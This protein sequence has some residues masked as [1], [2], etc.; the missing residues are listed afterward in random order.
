MSTPGSTIPTD[1]TTP[2]SRELCRDP[3]SVSRVPALRRWP[4]TA[5]LR[6]RSLS[7]RFS[8]RTAVV[9]VLMVLVLMALSVLGLMT[10]DYDLGPGQIMQALLGA[11]QDPL[12]GY[13]VNDLRAPRVVA[14][15]VVGAA[16]GVAGA[17]IQ[18]LTGNPLGSPDILGFTTGAATGALLQIIVLSGDGSQVALGALLGGLGT[19]VLVHLVTRGAGLTGTRLILVGLGV[20]AL[21]S[22]LNT[23]LV[24]R[25][26]L[27][28]A[29]TAAQWLAGSLNAMQW[30]RVLVTGALVLVLLLLAMAV[31]GAW[32]LLG[33]G[34][35]LAQSLG[36]PVTAVRTWSLLVA[37]ALVSLAT[38][39]TG[40]IAFVALAAPQIGRRLA[41]TAMPGILL[42]A[43]T[44]AALVL[45]SDIIAQRLLAPTQL[46]VGV[47][48]GALGGLYLIA[49]LVLDWKRFRP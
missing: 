2:N 30:H 5:T 43:L 29:Q 46:A 34:D 4:R 7:V 10:G 22:A 45:A 25:A 42:S 13:F 3:G 38:A 32:H 48:T 36:V 33:L 47:V 40:P 24:V 39:A 27:T 31:S 1:P 8:P 17:L 11:P 37:V 26:S 41:G 20:G 14:A 15:V 35:D 9:A 44:G 23:L 28:A 16:L 12:A 6:V 18:G 49:L 19:A 21:L